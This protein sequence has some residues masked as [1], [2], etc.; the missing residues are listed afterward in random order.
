MESSDLKELIDSKDPIQFM[1]DY[2]RKKTKDFIRLPKDHKELIKSWL[3][4][5]TIQAD[6]NSEPYLLSIYNDR[7]VSAVVNL[8]NN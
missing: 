6:N 4:L 5:K 2:V 7:A 3:T 1:K 8:E